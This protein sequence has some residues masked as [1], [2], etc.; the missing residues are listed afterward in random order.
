MAITLTYI[1]IAAIFL[2]P[3]SKVMKLKQAAVLS[4]F[5]P[6]ILLSAAIVAVWYVVYWCSKDL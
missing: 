5:W 1:L 6:V 2:W 3:L 4:L